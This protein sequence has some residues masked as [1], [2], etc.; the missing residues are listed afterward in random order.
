MRGGNIIDSKK[1]ERQKKGDV[2][3]WGEQLLLPLP[4]M[5]L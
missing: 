2:H 3:S 4:S 1:K 5:E